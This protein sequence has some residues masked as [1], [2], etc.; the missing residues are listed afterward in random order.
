MGFHLLSSYAGDEGTGKLCI[1]LNPL[2]AATIVG[3]T[4]Y[5]YIDM[6]EVRRL[7]SDV[8]R[9]IHQ[10][11]CG[12]IDPAAS[13][14]IGMDALIAYA[15]P[16]PAAGSTL[17]ERRRRIIDASAELRKLGWSVVEY[18]RGKFEVRR[19]ARNNV[20]ASPE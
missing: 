9:L 17:R 12:W 8:G 5:V 16:E 13:G 20:D 4:Q 11:L 19:P 3:G 10:R 7:E 1:A 15:W 2:L 6:I 18:A 14:R